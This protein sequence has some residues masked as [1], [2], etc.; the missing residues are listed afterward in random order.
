MSVVDIEPITYRTVDVPII[1][2][3]A[4]LPNGAVISGLS[5]LV[6]TVR[7]PYLTDEDKARLIAQL[8]EPDETGECWDDE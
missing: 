7:V 5:P 4:T 3:T 2:G 1:D 6:V 8:P